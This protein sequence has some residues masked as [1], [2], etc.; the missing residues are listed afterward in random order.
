MYRDETIDSQ[1]IL[2][3]ANKQNKI[4]TFIGFDFVKKK[5]EVL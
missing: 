5:D 3:V 2:F 4:I 1:N